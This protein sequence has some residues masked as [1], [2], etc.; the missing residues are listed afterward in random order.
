MDQVTQQ[1]AAMVE[2]TTAGANRLADEAVR[3]PRMI[4]QFK[5]R[6]CLA[7]PVRRAGRCEVHA[8]SDAPLA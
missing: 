3:L 7:F 8:N 6:Q 2:Q 5:N 4:G 1:N